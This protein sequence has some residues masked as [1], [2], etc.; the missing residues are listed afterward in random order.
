MGGEAKHKQSFVKKR[1]KMGHLSGNPGSRRKSSWTTN[2]LSL[3]GRGER[4][5][6]MDEEENGAEGKR[7]EKS[8]MQQN[9]LCSTMWE[10]ELFDKSTFFLNQLFYFF[11]M[12]LSR[13]YYSLFRTG[14]RYPFTFGGT[15]NLSSKPELCKSNFEANFLNLAPIKLHFSNLDQSEITFGC[16][17]CRLGLRSHRVKKSPGPISD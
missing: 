3:W 11:L 12:S 14:H 8:P 1:T 7:R 9:E 4:E 13:L 6:E 2:T 10:E 16:F 5:R 17:L 15:K